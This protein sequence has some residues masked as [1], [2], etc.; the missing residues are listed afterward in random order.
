MKDH[1]KIGAIIPSRY[2]YGQ[3]IP[4]SLPELASDE[5]AR[6]YD[7]SR[8]LVKERGSDA[9]KLNFPEARVLARIASSRRG[10]SATGRFTNLDPREYERANRIISDKLVPAGLVEKREDR[11]RLTNYA[12]SAQY[13][14]EPLSRKKG[15]LLMDI[16][17]G[18]LG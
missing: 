8:V 15:F 11:F 12:H 7:G 9:I 6:P 17:S 2:S 18:V 14:I 1:V 3:G 16:D 5:F 10:I 13:A 4:F